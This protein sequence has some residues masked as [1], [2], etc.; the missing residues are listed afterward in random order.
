MNSARRHWIDAVSGRIMSAPAADESKLISTRPGW[1]PIVSQR[2]IAGLQGTSSVI[3]DHNPSLMFDLTVRLRRSLLT[4]NES[5]TAQLI[6]RSSASS[7]TETVA[8]EFDFSAPPPNSSDSSSPDDDLPV[9]NFKMTR[10]ALQG[11]DRSGAYA[12]SD[13]SALG[14]ART[15]VDANSNNNSS[16]SAYSSR[17]DAADK[18]EFTLHGVLDRSIVEVY[19]NGGAEVGTMLYFADGVMDTVTLRR[20]GAPADKGVEFDFRLVALKSIWSGDNYGNGA[21]GDSNAQPMGNA[22]PVGKTDE[23]NIAEL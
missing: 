14:L 2:G 18:V 16:S 12:V 9:A 5:A 6:F 7:G 4:A 8:M 21:G 17:A 19:V 23:W 20:G 10:S 15:A 11:W 22:Q 1:N 13:V 3:R